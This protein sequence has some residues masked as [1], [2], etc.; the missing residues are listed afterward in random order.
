MNIPNDDPDFQFELK[1]EIEVELSMAE[2]SH[3]EEV[4]AL[5]IEEWLFDPVDVERE[6][7]ELRS[8]LGA[9]D[10]LDRNPRHDGHGTG[11]DT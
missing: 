2:E 8:L 10:E 4:F 3:P 5:P 9:V 7:V 6:E 11:E 1:E